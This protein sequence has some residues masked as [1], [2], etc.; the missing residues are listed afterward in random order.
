V[1]IHIC[2]HF[3]TKPVTLL[4]WIAYW[5]RRFESNWWKGHL[6]FLCFVF[7]PVMEAQSPCLSHFS[8]GH[9]SIH[10]R[11]ILIFISQFFTFLQNGRLPVGFSKISVR[12]SGLPHRN[13]CLIYRHQSMQAVHFPSAHMFSWLLFS[14]ICCSIRPHPNPWRRQ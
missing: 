11:A 14:D 5:D 7:Y 4:S 1:T 12:V 3:G 2:T 9:T 8:P 6:L 10:P 13:L